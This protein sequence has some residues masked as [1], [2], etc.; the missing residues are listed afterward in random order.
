[1]KMLEQMREIDIKDQNIFFDIMRLVFYSG[2]NS[3]ETSCFQ[4]KVSNTIH[5]HFSFPFQMVNDVVL[6]MDMCRDLSTT[7]DLHHDNAQIH[8]VLFIRKQFLNQQIF[9]DRMGLPGKLTNS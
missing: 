6:C 5:P 2:W 7:L 4:L 9:E 3:E 8:I 1:M